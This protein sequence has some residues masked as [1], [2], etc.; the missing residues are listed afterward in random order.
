MASVPPSLSTG[1]EYTWEIATIYPEQGRWTER[2][3]LAVTEVSNRRIEFVDG[4]LEF[5][6]MP[7][8]RHQDLLNFLYEALKFLATSSAPGCVYQ[9]INIRMACG[10]IRVPDIVYVSDADSHLLRDDVSLGATLVAEVVSPDPRDRQRDYEFKLAEYAE[11]GIAEYWI[12]DPE[13]RVIQVHCLD[14]DRYALHGEFHEGDRATS[15]ILSGLEVD[16]TAMFASMKKLPK[17]KQ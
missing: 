9:G 7:T 11:T 3:Y 8:I 17:T 4:R 14:G 12:V 6:P 2:E 5:L 15:T 1:P 16:V 10:P 13:L